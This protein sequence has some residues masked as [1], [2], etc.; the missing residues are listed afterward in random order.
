MFFSIVFVH[1]G[2]VV[3][4]DREKFILLNWRGTW[5]TGWLV[6]VGWKIGMEGLS[7][8]TQKGDEKLVSS[9]VYLFTVLERFHARLGY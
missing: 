9:T 6:Q 3:F 8:A 4:L 5:F 1:L 7:F 2:W